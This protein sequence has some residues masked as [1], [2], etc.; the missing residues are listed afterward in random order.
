MKLSRKA[1][2]LI[3]LTLMALLIVGSAGAVAAAGR[4]HG[5]RWRNIAPDHL[6]STLRHGWRN[7]ENFGLHANLLDRASIEAAAANALAVSPEELQSAVAAGRD[8]VQA[9]LDAADLELSD[10]QSTVE[11]EVESQLAAA[12]EAGTLTQEEMDDMLSH[13]L[14]RMEFGR[15]RHGRFGKQILPTGIDTQAILQA[16]AANAGWDAEDLLAALTEGRSALDTFLEANDATPAEFQ[17]T[18]DTALQQAIDDAVEAGT[19]TEEQADRLNRKGAFGHGL[20]RGR[21]H[22]RWHGHGWQG[23]FGNFSPA[24]DNA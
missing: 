7:H 20:D 8:G 18:L 10:L 14:S 4:Q 16:V 3:I 23:I 12:V 15:G 24:G 6:G 19:L 2:W 1:R 13:G 21:H 22:G 11:A 9:L 5:L 17:A